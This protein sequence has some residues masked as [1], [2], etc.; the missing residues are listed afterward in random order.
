MTLPSDPPA[1]I[2]LHA[3][4]VGALLLDVSGATFSSE[5][6][7]RIWTLAA[8][9]SGS[10]APEGVREA[11]PGV[12]NLLMVYDPLVLPS[13]QASEELRQWWQQAVADPRGGREVEVPVIYGGEYGEDLGGFAAELGLSVDEL[14]RRHSAVTYTVT[15]IGAMP[16][17]PYLA[18]LP[19]EL[20]RPRRT[21]PRTRVEG[22]SIM[23]GGAQGG[24][25]PITGP[26]GWHVLGRTTLSL[27]D[28]HRRTPCT[29]MPGD[30]VRIKVLEVHA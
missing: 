7:Q 22:G 12:N 28:P 15:C 18:G 21:V 30:K 10:Q 9:L 6:Q 29:F 26:S 14:V 1:D 19:P 5:L 13:A 11:V 3:A 16:G 27:F 4:G 23:I 20:A 24:I 25:M 8:R 2:R 17:F